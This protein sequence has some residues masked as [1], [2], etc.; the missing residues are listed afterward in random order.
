[1]NKPITRREFLR[2]GTAAAVGLTA[3]GLLAGCVP[4][5]T[6]AP[7]SAPADTQV[8]AVTEEEA[9]LSLWHRYFWE[10]VGPLFE[11]FAERFHE[12][13][14][15]ISLEMNLSGDEDYKSAIT[16]AIA[17]GDPPD[18]FYTYG[19]NWLKFF[20][21]EGLLADL[22]PYWEQYKWKDRLD[23]KS[24]KGAIYDGTP[25]AVPTELTTAGVYYN[26]SIFQD[27]G[28]E[29][30]EVPTWD[31]FLG[32]CDKFKAAGY[33]PLC[34]GDKEGSQMQ[35][36]WDYAVV[37]ENGNNYRKQVVRGEIPLNDQGVL[38]GLDRIMTD[39]FN[40]GLMNDNIVGMSWFDWFG[41]FA[42]GQTAMTLVH[43]FIPPQFLPGLM[44]DP[45]ELGFFLYPQVHDD[46]EIANDLY[47]EGFQALSAVGEHKDAGAKWLDHMI[48]PEVQTE[49]AEVSFIPVVKGT[50]ESL[51]PLTKGAYELVSKHDTFAH[52][53]LVFHPEV[54]TAIL[55]NLQS[56]VSG[57]LTPKEAMDAAQA[58]AETAPWVGVPQGEAG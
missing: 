41:M 13:N 45:F 36:W 6:P 54:K 7:S 22:T 24:L 58:V 17:S 38:A 35:W 30:P 57:E 23:E 18:I 53:D 44:T 42:E 31:E 16:V 9:V 5:P 26:K 14:P 8:P 25:Y 10:P 48:S 1:M 55:S 43:S 37:R 40:A 52:L 12:Q 28:I 33:Q 56:M 46:I 50:E 15:N 49:W 27:V 34:L 29:P 19:G 32:Y 3:Q 11:S 20:V 4:A 21:D 2:I 39:V 51:P 47:V